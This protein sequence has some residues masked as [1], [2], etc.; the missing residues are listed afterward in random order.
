[1]AQVCDV[2]GVTVGKWTTASLLDYVASAACKRP[3]TTVLHVNIHAIN[4][5]WEDANFKN[6][7]NSA[8]AVFCDGDGIRVIGRLAGW[9]L[10]EKITYNRWIWQLAERSVD[11]GLT[12]FVLGDDEE[13]NRKA[14][15]ILRSRHPRLIICGRSHGFF[16]VGTVE[17]QSILRA[18]SHAKPD[19][20]LVGMGMPRQEKWLMRCRTQLNCGVA[21]SVGAAIA[22]VS[23][24]AVMPPPVYVTLKLEWLYRLLHEPRRLWRRYLIG[25]PLFVWRVARSYRPRFSLRDAGR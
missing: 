13:T 1:M 3:C 24:K 16:R 20:L 15:E 21:L 23:G 8:D 4:L 22:Y 9:M 12:W 17:E 14:V 10:P 11:N 6:I 5:A 18:I 7:L 2:L 19:I 25:N